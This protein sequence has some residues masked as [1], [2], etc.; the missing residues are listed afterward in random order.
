MCDTY[1]TSTSINF[2]NSRKSCAGSLIVLPV[3]LLDETNDMIFLFQV[4]LMY[5]T[6]GENEEC[7]VGVLHTTHI[8]LIT[9]HEENQEAQIERRRNE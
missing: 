5:S 6:D 3:I 7:S 9:S 8:I 2:Q 4:E 1:S